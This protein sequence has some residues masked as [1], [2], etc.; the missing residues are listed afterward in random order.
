[1][2]SGMANTSK[3]K[4]YIMIMPGFQI[5]FPHCF[6]TRGGGG[7]GEMVGWEGRAL[8]PVTAQ[9]F[10]LP[11]YHADTIFMILSHLWITTSHL[12]MTQAAIMH[13][14]FFTEWPVTSFFLEKYLSIWL[15]WVLVLAWGILSRGTQDLVPQSEIEPWAP[16]LGA[17]SLSHRTIREL[18]FHWLIMGRSSVTVS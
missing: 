2:W 15:C 17:W 8:L 5:Q 9:G 6:L 3:E 18:P 14:S 12:L 7:A 4:P 10:I 16:V 1:M 13:H 11:H